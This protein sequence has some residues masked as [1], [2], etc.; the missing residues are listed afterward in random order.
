MIFDS[1]LSLED[2][3]KVYNDMERKFINMLSEKIEVS[4][5]RILNNKDKFVEKNVALLGKIGFRKIIELENENIMG[6]VCIYDK[7]L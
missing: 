4:K 5:I 6:A 7:Y 3:A 2:M 1:G